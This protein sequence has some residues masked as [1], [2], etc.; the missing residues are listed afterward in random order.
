MVVNSNWNSKLNLNFVYRSVCVHKERKIFS[1]F[2]SFS[3][4]EAEK[5]LRK[6]EQVEAMKVCA[7]T[8]SFTQLG[9]SLLVIASTPPTKSYENFTAKVRQYNSMEPFKFVLPSIF[10]Q[11]NF[12]EV[13]CR[14][15]FK[16]VY[17]TTFSLFP[18]MR[19]IYMILLNCMHGL[20]INF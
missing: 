10:F 17:K 14:M 11:N 18:Y 19:L 8:E 2:I 6:A 3:K 5:Y 20:L 4:R 1:C 16:Q 9:R 13:S 7:E 12:L 15:I